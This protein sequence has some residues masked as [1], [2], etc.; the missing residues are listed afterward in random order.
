MIKH[1]VMWKLKEIGAGAGKQ[2]NA[3]KL[4]RL[5]EELKSSIPEVIKIE[6]GVNLK[7]S[8]AA[9][10]VVLYSEFSNQVALD[11]YQRH[12]DHLKVVDFVREIVSERRVVDY[13]V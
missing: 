3:R 4:K 7:E 12:P 11:A 2:E 13:E 8:E 10:D 5:L 6:A 9:S 1:I